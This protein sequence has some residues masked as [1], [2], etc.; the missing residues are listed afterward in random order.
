MKFWPKL[1]IKTMNFS[2]ILKFIGCPRKY[3]I[4][5]KAELLRFTPIPFWKAIEVYYSDLQSVLVDIFFIPKKCRGYLCTGT[6]FPAPLFQVF[7]CV[8]S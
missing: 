7:I 8:R 5:P 1:D 6:G 3:E 4:S 2:K